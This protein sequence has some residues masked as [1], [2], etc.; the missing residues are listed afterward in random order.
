ME[1]ELKGAN[2]TWPPETVIQRNRVSLQKQSH[3]SLQAL[4]DV[5]TFSRSTSLFP[6]TMNLKKITPATSPQMIS[7]ILTTLYE[8]NLISLLQLEETEGW[9]K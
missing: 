3:Q 4:T 2:C 5:A 7:V 1:S 8:G 9:E 6:N